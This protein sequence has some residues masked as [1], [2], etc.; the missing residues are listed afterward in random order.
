MVNVPDPVQ[1]VPLI[2]QVPVIVFPFTV[3]VSVRVFPAGVPEFTVSP[4]VPV[5]LPSVFPVSVNDPDSVWP[6][7]KQEELLLKVKLEMVSDPL[8][9]TARFVPNVKAVT[10]LESTRV[11][12]H[13]PL[14]FD[15]L[16]L[17]D[18]QPSK[19]RPTTSNTAAAN[20]FI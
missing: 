17:L 10:L 7:T 9:F 2:V 14:M 3:P 6:D 13:V 12:L 16:E 15:E 5:T 11:A 19:A 4:N 1:P 18:P 8:P 20:G